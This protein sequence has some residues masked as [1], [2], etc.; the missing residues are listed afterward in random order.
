[1]IGR[2]KTSANPWTSTETPAERVIDEQTE[3]DELMGERL[4][5]AGPPVP[6][7]LDLKG[8]ARTL[9][10]AALPADGRLFVVGLHGGSGATTVARLL[11]TSVALDAER[12]VPQHSVSDRPRV[13]LV[14][15]TNGAG[16]VA[17]RSAAQ[18]WAAGDIDDVDLL[19]LVLVADG[20]RLSKVLKAQALAVAGLTPRC[21]R[22]EWR[23]D[24]REQA[25]PELDVR[26]VRLRRV[27]A[28]I[29][30]RATARTTERNSR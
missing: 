16:L 7:G 26:S 10:R 9:R 6:V 11:G 4:A 2:R 8:R 1:V 30:Q 20:P 22:I 14:A 5:I 13:L 21:W 25:V 23:D 28:D 3:P 19:G 15:R 24:W 29:T 18:E 27:L 12:Q 17:A